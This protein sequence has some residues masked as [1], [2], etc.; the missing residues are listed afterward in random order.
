MKKL[1]EALMQVEEHFEDARAEVQNDYFNALRE[2]YGDYDKE[3]LQA[4]K[5]QLEVKLSELKKH[6][7]DLLPDVIQCGTL[8]RTYAVGTLMESI[9]N[10][11]TKLDALNHIFEVKYAD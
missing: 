11:E 7:V 10:V 1:S 9:D 8:E 5:E 6:F 3:T 4:E 2:M